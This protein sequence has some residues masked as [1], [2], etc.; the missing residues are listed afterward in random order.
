MLIYVLT[1]QPFDDFCLRAL[2]THRVRGHSFIRLFKR[3]S[4]EPLRYFDHVV[5]LVLVVLVA[6]MVPVVLVLLVVLVVDLVILMDHVILVV[7]V[8]VDVLVAV[9]YHNNHDMVIGLWLSSQL[10][11]VDNLVTSSLSSLSTCS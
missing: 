9:C 4:R 1:I 5:H 8:D 2:I 3:D 7:I 10:A 6:I 11:D